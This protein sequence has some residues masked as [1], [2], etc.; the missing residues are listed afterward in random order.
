MINLGSKFFLI[1]AVAIL[2][3]PVFSYEVIEVIDG[4]TITANIDGMIESVRFLGIDTPE[5]QNPYRDEECFGQEASAR[6]KELLAGKD[7]VLEGDDG[8]GD[9]DKY[10]RLLRYVYVDGV[11]VNELL[12]R[13]GYAYAYTDEDY[14]YRDDFIDREQEAYQNRAG[15]WAEGACDGFERKIY[16]DYVQFFLGLRDI[17][18][19]LLIPRIRYNWL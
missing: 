18:R 16:K 17:F 12:I 4:D 3:L 13:E 19:S 1:L 14:K 2:P 8:A 6:T 9:R 7:V 11:F 5:V 15:L 10:G